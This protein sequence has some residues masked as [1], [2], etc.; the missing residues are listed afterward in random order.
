MIPDELRGIKV[1]S[2]KTG[3]RSNT[4]ASLH[5]S[6]LTSTSLQTPKHETQ[7]AKLQGGD[8]GASRWS[9]THF[10]LFFRKGVHED[11]VF[12]WFS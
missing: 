3:F 9:G 11:V 4:D 8:G 7:P 10:F 1:S 12:V 5:T 6:I 2:G